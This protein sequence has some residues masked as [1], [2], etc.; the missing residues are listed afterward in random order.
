MRLVPV[1]LFIYE[2]SPAMELS[3]LFKVPVERFS[4]TEDV[5]YTIGSTGDIV[6]N[7]IQCLIKSLEFSSSKSW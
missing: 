1:T 7:G 4:S 5:G 2:R 3:P 6:S